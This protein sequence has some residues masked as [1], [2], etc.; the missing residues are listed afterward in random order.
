VIRALLNC[1][2]ATSHA[3]RVTSGSETKSVLYDWVESSSARTALVEQAPNPHG[4]YVMKSRMTGKACCGSSV[5][6]LWAHF[7]KRSKRTSY[8]GSAAAKSSWHSIGIIGSASPPR[9]NVGR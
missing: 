5:I 6:T 3:G 1:C 9:T 2:I 4:Q 8:G 7:G